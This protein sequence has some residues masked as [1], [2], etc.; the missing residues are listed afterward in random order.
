MH[1]SGIEKIKI[2]RLRAQKEGVTTYIMLEE[3]QS[4]TILQ[5]QNDLE[6]FDLYAYQA[7][8]NTATKFNIKRGRISNFAWDVPF[9]NS[10]EIMID[11]IDASG[12]SYRVTD[13]KFDVNATHAPQEFFISGKSGYKQAFWFEAKCQE[14]RKLIRIYE[15]KSGSLLK[16]E[17]LGSTKKTS[18]PEREI[19][20]GLASIGVS[21]VGIVNQTRMECFY[22]T[23]IG[24]EL[25]VLE[26][27]DNYEC[28]ARIKFLNVDANCTPRPL[29][30][31]MITSGNYEELCNFDSY[32][33]DSS[34]SLVKD[35]NYLN[36]SLL[37]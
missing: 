22:L 19:V 1:S 25:G 31:V 37:L 33:I 12:K 10:R 18:S 28:Q 26:H 30:P 5:I 14:G 21:F 20:V 6:E 11:L 8:V 2:F 29:H 34:F 15:T 16:N 23:V 13:T 9:L 32:A 17:A 27:T 35:R 7:G 4:K 3:C 24:A 36:V